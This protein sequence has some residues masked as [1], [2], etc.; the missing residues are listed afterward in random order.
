MASKEGLLSVVHFH[1]YADVVA[2]RACRAKDIV[3]TAGKEM[4]TKRKAESHSRAANRP[5]IMKSG[6]IRADLERDSGFSGS[7]LLLHMF[8]RLDHKVSLN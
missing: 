6:D 2:V 5:R 7:T 1:S 8:M 4:S 3:S